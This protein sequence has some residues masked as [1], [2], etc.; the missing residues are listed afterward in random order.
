MAEALL[1]FGAN[2][3][4]AA[5]TIERALERLDGFSLPAQEGRVGQ[6]ATRV[7]PPRPEAPPSVTRFA[8]ATSRFGGRQEE[9]APSPG[10]ERGPIRLLARSSLYRTPPWGPVPQPEFVNACAVVRTDLSA[11]DLLLAAQDVERALGRVPGERWGPR[12]LDIDLLDYDGIALQE[13]GLTLPHPRLH[14]RAFVLVP[15]A[16]IAPDRVVARRRVT[17]WLE[18]VDATGIR[19]LE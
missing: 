5:A 14:E 9:P 13:P 8:P 4:D 16:E 6:G 11:R 2:L 17:E 12:A 18:G 19:R 1:S 10:P 3:G 15:L 7:G